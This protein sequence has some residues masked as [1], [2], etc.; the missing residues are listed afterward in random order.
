MVETAAASWAVAEL[1]GANLGDARL[2]RRLVRVA[3]R[4]GA[5]PGASI[6]VA[7]GGWAE[8]QGAYRLLAHEAVD[9]EAVLT[10]HWDCSIERMRGQPVV[11]CV[12]DS[13]ELNY[14]SQPGIAGLGP[15]SSLRRHGLYVHPT[16][17]VT[18]DGVPLGV[19]D[20]W[21]WARDRATF[22]E[23]KRH[24]P[25][26]AK[27]SMR[28]L[29]GFARCAELAETL[30]DTRL[31][32]VAD[33]ECDIHEFMIRARRW[34]GI[35]WLVRATHNRCL[36]EGDKL[37]DRLAQAPLLGEVTFTLPARPNRP[38]RPVVLTV[39][40]ERVTLSPKGAE[41]VTV[42]ALRARE[43]SAPDGVE[44]LDWRLLTN[45]PATTL[46]QAAELLNWYGS[47]WSIEVFFR[48]F[49][50]GCR[51]EALQLSTVERLEPALALYLIIAWRIQYLTA[52]GRAATDLPCDMAGGLRR[53]SPPPSTSPPAVTAGHARLDRPPGRSFGAQMRWTTRSPSPLDRLAAGARSRLGDGIGFRSPYPIN[54]LEMCGIDRYWMERTDATPI[55]GPGPV[56]G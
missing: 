18:P 4:L 14:T 10:P 53:D 17:A 48:I 21:M 19:L 45:R 32:Y 50:T 37:W 5:Q 38:S 52:L 13:T 12:Q 35:D 8:T 25:I 33:R 34:P 27:E 43:A 46:A 40:A 9:W 20:A 56:F 44:P 16:L 1:G 55:V 28:W 36:A 23:D 24:W 42:T 22:G 26:E 6:P 7:C 11:L 2:S 31:I 39:R 49:K 51:V 54:R 3:E 29:E 30:P 15:L 47:R 41:P